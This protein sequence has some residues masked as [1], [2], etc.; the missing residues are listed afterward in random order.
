MD[1]LIL[2]WL[3]LLLGVPAIIVPI[4]LLWG[5]AGCGIDTVGNDEPVTDLSSKPAAPT[6]LKATAMGP[7]LIKLRWDDNTGGT[8]KFR[9][10][11]V[12]E[13]TSDTR[14]FENLVKPE[15]ED[16]VDLKEGTTYFYTVKATLAGTDSDP[17]NESKVTAFP[18]APS[19]LVATPEEVGRIDLRWTNNSK[20][21]TQFIILDRLIPAGSVTERP[22]PGG[23]S[24]PVPLPVAEGSAHEFRVVATQVGYQEG[25]LQ[26]Q[27][28]SLPSDPVTAKPL[29]FKAELTANEPNPRQGYCL[30]QRIPSSLLSNQ[31]TQVTLTVRGSSAGGLTIDRIFISQ[32]VQPPASGSLWDSHTDL[33]KVVDISQG[34]QAVVLPA[35]DPR[36]TLG[37][38]VY[39]LDRSKDLLIAFDISAVEGQGNL[40]RVALQGAV[41]YLKAAISEAKIQNRGPGY[42][43]EPNRHYLVEKIEVL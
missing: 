24:Q 28:R 11:R 23:A 14:P 36:K 13:G 2:D 17:S 1:W 43:A 39:T 19:N 3:I 35:S 27:I 42:N 38:F 16:T 4:V 33:T 25:V 15:F 40:R 6:N 41:A 26:L 21:A 32:P 20:T 31:G 12:E 37:P 7:N 9:G 5:F 10:V 34:N 30:V 8:T 29:A 18:A 22:V